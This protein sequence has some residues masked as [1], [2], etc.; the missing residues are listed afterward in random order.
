MAAHYRATE[1]KTRQSKDERDETAPQASPHS[2]MRARAGLQALLLGGFLPDEVITVRFEFLRDLRGRPK[3]RI[4]SSET[5]R[6]TIFPFLRAALVRCFVRH[7][8]R[9]NRQWPR[10]IVA[11]FVWEFPIRQSLIQDTQIPR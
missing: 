11:P 3:I 9:A 10:G 6:D 1:E 2:A 8:R 7:M 4:V 5:P